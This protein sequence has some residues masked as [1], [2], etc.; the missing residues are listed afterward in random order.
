MLIEKIEPIDMPKLETADAA[1]TEPAPT[2]VA[3]GAPV[4][5]ETQPLEKESAEEAVKPT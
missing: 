2:E 3:E 4:T 1:P 5:V